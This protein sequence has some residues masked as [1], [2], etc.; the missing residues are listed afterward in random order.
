MNKL[1]SWIRYYFG[2]S[3]TE[4]NGTLVLFILI[5]III[6]IPIIWDALIFRSPYVN[7]QDQKKLDSL[8]A[9]IHDK[10]PIPESELVPAEL[11][12][13]NPNDI[14]KSDFIQ[15]G[16]Q[17]SE[18]QR[19][20]NYR[21]AGGAFKIKS[22]LKKIY[23]FSEQ[24]YLRIEGYIDLPDQVAV[25]SVEFSE[26]RESPRT[27]LT[28]QASAAERVYF[29]IN[30]ADSLDLVTVKGI[31]P[32]L[33]TRIMKYRKALGGFTHPEQYYE[34]YGLPYDVVKVLQN[35]SY[36]EEDFKPVQINI[37]FANRAEMIR[38]PYFDKELTM[39]IIELRSKT[40][41]F[42]SMEALPVT[43]LMSDSILN[44][45]KPYISF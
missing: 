20:V 11:F 41:P 26:K 27:N 23:G 2:F 31:G 8:I 12:R 35:S 33:A 43:E 38:H 4:T 39:N 21:K 3:R 18:A 15:L 1:K 24:D 7:D 14:P 30:K 28:V 19:I 13:F 5:L 40:G 34:I 10:K 45:L 9:T 17:E 25:R 37:N 6:L 32:I 22:D 36:I 42:R 44:K 16:L 29:D